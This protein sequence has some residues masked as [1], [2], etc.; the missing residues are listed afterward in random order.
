MSGAMSIDSALAHFAAKKTEYLEDL[1]TLVRIPSVSFD[2]F[3]PK[4]VR[5]SA[6]ATAVLLKKR[7]F[8]NVQLL[9]I[10]GARRPDDSGLFETLPLAVRPAR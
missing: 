1:K 10:E 6:E 3:D 2:G 7:G 5:Q 4:L 9:E 8:Q